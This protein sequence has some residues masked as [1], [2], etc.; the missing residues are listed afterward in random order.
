MTQAFEAECGLLG[1]ILIDESIMSELSLMPEHFEEGRNKKIY[2]AMKDLV[3][4][5][6]A[7]DLVNLISQMGRKSIEYIGGSSYFSQLKE[8]VVSVHSFKNYERIIIDSWKARS[9]KNILKNVYEDPNFKPDNLQQVIKQ[10]NEIDESGTQEAFNLQEC[11]VEMYELPITEVPKGYSGVETGLHALDEMT[12]GFQDEDL[13]IVGA[14]PSMGKTALLLNIAA[15]AGY[16]K[17][18]PIIFSLEMSA[19]ALVKR[20]LCM[21]GNID[22]EKARNPYHDFNDDDKKAWTFAIGILERM[23][24]QIFDKPGQTVNE[25][26]AK[27]R[28]IKKANPDSKVLVMI[29]Y[30]TL[31]K[32]ENYHNGNTN[33]Q[34]SEIS[35]SLKAMAKEFKSPVVCLSQLSRSVEA[36]AN[37]R[38]MMSD[39]R[40]SGSIEQDADV[41][42][43]LYRDEYY[44]KDTEKKDILEINIAKQRNG[45]TG[46]IELYYNKK[47][48]KIKDLYAR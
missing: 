29:D 43:F 12:D 45:P 24:L 19:A 10:L 14:R 9:A 42:G 32:S 25:M 8:N 40:D 39:L 16:K 5:E 7:I 26:R 23:N 2:I 18:I 3:R 11:L 13:I 44:N 6:K 27:V 15:R 30:L 48:Q 4:D 28:Q 33:L 35:N 37:K 17:V 31:I 47:T 38:P 1:S 34:V 20:L 22:G 46:K 36:R 21:I 41:I